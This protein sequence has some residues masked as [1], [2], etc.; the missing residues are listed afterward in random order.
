ML[1]NNLN[2]VFYKEY[3]NGLLN[4]KFDRGIRKCNETLLE[5][6]VHN[7]NRCLLDKELY[8]MEIDLYVNYPGLLVGTG[9]IHTTGL[10]ND[11]IKMGFNFDYVSGLPYI[12]ATSV[13]GT[14]K[15]A[16][17]G[18]KAVYVEQNLQLDSC[19]IT[20]LKRKIFGDSAESGV[21]KG[22][23]IFFDARI[24]EGNFKNRILGSDN[25]TPHKS[26]TT[27]PQPI[28]ILKILPG[29]KIRFYFYL[30][31]TTLKD[32]TMVTAQQKKELF[33]NILIDFG[34]G[35]KTNTG[36]GVLLEKDPEEDKRNTTTKECGTRNVQSLAIPKRRPINKKYEAVVKSINKGEIKV[37]VKIDGAP[38]YYPK[39][40]KNQIFKDNERFLCE[41][42]S[43]FNVGDILSITFDEEQTNRAK[44]E[45]NDQT[46]EIQNKMESRKNS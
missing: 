43:T 19:K 1:G 6:Q 35:A 34:I 18:E 9:Y 15:Q 8:N 46:Q 5:A 17:S 11:E 26:I 25:I 4:D 31:D 12:P 36:Y 10:S 22:E 23:D 38:M 40:K 37:I 2:Y 39:I 29:V 27:E 24:L 28:N 33:K 13:K 14:L 45:Y 42:Q 30:T 32:G 3:Y 44:I 41:L 20:E 7:S 16:F 21:G